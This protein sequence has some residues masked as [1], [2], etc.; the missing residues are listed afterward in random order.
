MISSFIQILSRIIYFIWT[1]FLKKNNIQ[2]AGLTLKFDKCTFAAS[3]L[4]FLAHVITEKG[5]AVLPEKIEAVR[6]SRSFVGITNYY[7]RFV[8]NFS[9]VVSPSHQL[10]ASKEWCWTTECQQS[11]ETIKTL[12]TSAPLLKRPDFDKPFIVYTDASDVGIGGL[13]TQVY[14]GVEHIIGYASR[15][16][17]CAEKNCGVSERE[18]LAIVHLLK[19]FRTYVH[20][21]HFK[22]VTDHMSLTWLAKLHETNPRLTR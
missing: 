16:L 3:E 10:A 15:T 8:P 18:C 20:G 21:T 12:L 5:V 19:E 11:F 9:T 22:V 17:S 4:K 7:R 6:N 14:D 1:V 13:L 2:E